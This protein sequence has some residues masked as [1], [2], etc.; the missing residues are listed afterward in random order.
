MSRGTITPYIVQRPGETFWTI[1]EKH[2]QQCGPAAGA[3]PPIEDIRYLT[4]WLGTING[5][6]H[7]LFPGQRVFFGRAHEAVA[8]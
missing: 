1:A 3:R 2:L 6:D 4:T 8:D 5:R 7:C